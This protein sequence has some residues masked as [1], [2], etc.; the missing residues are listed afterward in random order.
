MLK[1]EDF[2]A[3]QRNPPLRRTSAIQDAALL[4]GY[5]KKKDHGFFGLK[6]QRYLRLFPGLL[7]IFDKKGDAVASHSILIDSLTVISCTSEG[8]VVE[9]TSRELK[10][11]NRKTWQFIFENGA[12]AFDWTRAIHAATRDEGSSEVGG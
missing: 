9:V 5:V 3:V 4:E 8:R 11:K 2:V 6:H 10:S 1:V 12:A 7:H